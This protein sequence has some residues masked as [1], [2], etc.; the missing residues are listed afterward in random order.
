MGFWTGKRVLVTGHTGF[1][2]SW[3][4]LWL[5]EL[6]AE[7]HGLAL[8]PDTDPALFDQLELGD[9]P[10]HRLGDIRDADLLHRRVSE[11]QPDAVFH[12]AAQPLVLEG[13]R[14]PVE[15]W[16]SN[17]MGTVHLLDALRSLD[18]PCAAVIVTTDK[19]YENREWVHPYREC[20]RLGGRDPYSASKA[21]C[22]IAVASFRASFF[23]TGHPV[24]I[25]SARAGNVIGGGDWAENRILPD[26]VRALT[27]DRPVPV[28]NP[29]ARR[30]WQHVLEPL[31]GYLR[32]AERLWQGAAP[33]AE[34]YNFGPEVHN[35]RPVRD[36]VEGALAHWPG[37]QWQDASDPDA[38]HEAGLLSLGI[39]RARADLGYVPRW[40]FATG[41][42]RSMEWYRAVHE[43]ADPRALTRR[44]IAEFGAP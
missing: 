28:R 14:D 22:E 34:A 15:T 1:K 30:P 10:G 39:E 11:V 6:G 23:G 9:L 44:Q 13:Y 31:S 24:R 19:V 36:L 3:L 38:P 16:R 42:A 17:V 41:L 18:R 35:V 33:V 37:G 40:D 29:S 7:V 25:A 5:S 12:L 20:D 43:G 8:A 32:L 21:G 26:I 2:G 4:T 27:A